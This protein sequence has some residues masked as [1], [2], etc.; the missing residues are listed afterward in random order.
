MTLGD[1]PRM[2]VSGT[3]GGI[4]IRDPF[5]VNGIGEH[6]P[7]HSKHLVGLVAST[8]CF[9]GALE[10]QT[11]TTGDRPDRPLAKHRKDLVLQLVLVVLERGGS[12]FAAGARQPFLCRFLEGHRTRAL[13]G[14]ALLCLQ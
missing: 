1:M 6:L 10:V 4:G 7:K 3:S 8:P 13:D 5:V 2:G 9:D 12:E 14:L 11:F